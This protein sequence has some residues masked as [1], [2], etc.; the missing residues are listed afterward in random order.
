MNVLNT[1]F[2]QYNQG[3]AAEMAEILGERQTNL[4]EQEADYQ[5]EYADSLARHQLPLQEL[6]S[7]MAGTPVNPLNPGAI[8]TTR[9]QPTDVLGAYRL[10]TEARMN[11]FNQKVAMDTAQRERL[12]DTGEAFINFF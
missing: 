9:V 8:S 11:N 7:I 5:R 3:R 2:D 6:M 10:H 1:G 12:Q 4:A